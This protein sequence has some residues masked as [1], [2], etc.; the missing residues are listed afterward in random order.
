M[1]PVR[2]VSE[3]MA[4]RDTAPD[5]NS[6]TSIEP[7]TPVLAEEIGGPSHRSG[8]R[9]AARGVPSDRWHRARENL[10]RLPL[11]AWPSRPIVSG[12]LL[13]S[14]SRLRLRSPTLPANLLFDPAFV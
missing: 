11:V 7:V 6:G 12:Y 4:P 2:T 13:M 10:T 1:S 14:T 8:I 9:R 3:P 5:T